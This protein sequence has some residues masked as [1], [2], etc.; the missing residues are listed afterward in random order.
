VTIGFCWYLLFGLRHHDNADD[1]LS[2][3]LIDELVTKSTVILP[4]RQW[5]RPKTAAERKPRPVEELNPKRLYVVKFAR[6]QHDLRAHRRATT[7]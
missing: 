2:D 3:L 7:H 5:R 1:T 4:V 6:V